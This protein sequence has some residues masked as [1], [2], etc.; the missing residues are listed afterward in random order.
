MVRIREMLV[1]KQSQNEL[2]PRLKQSYI[3][4]TNTFR[5]RKLQS[6]RHL[7]SKGSLEKGKSVIGSILFH[8]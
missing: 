7:V 3:K 1:T 4:S 2:W 8:G 5:V 6:L